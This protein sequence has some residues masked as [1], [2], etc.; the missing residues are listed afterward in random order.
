MTGAVRKGGELT[1]EQRAQLVY[2]R[3][4][5]GLTQKELA[6]KYKVGDRTVRQ[7]V[8]AHLETIVKDL[9][10]EVQD[11]RDRL[12]AL[13]ELFFKQTKEL[14][15]PAFSRECRAAQAELLA[16]LG[17]NKEGDSAAL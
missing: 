6:R 5:N 11:A 4:V 9:E 12:K 3:I 2:D 7:V 14:G 15:D 10:Q 17:Y 1:K 13:T 16:Y 8:K